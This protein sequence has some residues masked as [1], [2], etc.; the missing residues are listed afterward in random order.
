MRFKGHKT[1]VEPLRDT[2][3][4]YNAVPGNLGYTIFMP[5]E[6]ATADILWVGTI[7]YLVNNMWIFDLVN[8][9]KQRLTDKELDEAIAQLFMVIGMR[10]GKIVFKNNRLL[11]I[12]R[13]F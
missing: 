8:E 5:H 10:P 7:R 4:Y 12:D 6:S 3:L 11:L 1:E 13:R 2:G 9:D